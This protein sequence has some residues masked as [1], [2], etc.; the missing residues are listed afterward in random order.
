MWWFLLMIGIYKITSPSNK[1]YIGQSV[2]IKKRFYNYKSLSCK[3]QTILHNSFNKYGV[4]NHQFD[5]V[6][7]C[8]IHLLN[9]RERY[10]QDYYDVVGEKGLNC[11]LTKTEDKSGKLSKKTI[12]KIKKNRKGIPSKFKDSASRGLNISKSLT[13][14]KLS[15]EHKKSLS[16]AQT[17]L[18]R[19]AESIKKSADSRRGLKFDDHFKEGIRKRQTGKT[20]SFAKI[21]LNTETGIFYET[22][23]EAAA[24]IG[25]TYN[26]M[27]HYMN[28]RTKKKLPFIYV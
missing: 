1:I 19:S 11:L 7:E 2:D 6:E 15:E 10:W 4:Y 23:I 24:S 28:G 27:N 20:N 12:D 26:R 18:K 13:G 9:E 21:V 16:L 25:W 14:K 8:P 17:G 3:S 22:A 5:V